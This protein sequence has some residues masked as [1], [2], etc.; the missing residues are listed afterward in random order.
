[1]A[2]KE[3]S[4]DNK[5]SPA[6]PGKVINPAQEQSSDDLP[7]ANLDDNVTDQAVKDIAT[8]ESDQVLAVEDAA[9]QPPP[10]S[11]G[12][13]KTK[14]KRILKDK[15]TWIG[16]AVVLVLL[17][18]VPVTRYKVL[19]LVLK[20]PVTVTVVDSQSGHPVSAAQVEFGGAT[21][22]TDG[23]GQVRLR[24]KVGPQTIVA[25]KQYYKQT[26]SKYFVGLKSAK[27]KTVKLTATGRLVPVTVINKITGQ[28]LKGA[29][30]KVLN[31]SAKTDNKGRAV[32]ALPAKHDTEKVKLS[33]SGYNSVE[34]D[35]QVTDQAVKANNFRLV[36]A[37]HIYFLSNLSG[38]IDVVR[39]NLDGSARKTVFKGTGK[40]DARSTSLL[41][42][43]DWRYAVLKSNREG[44]QASLFV[45]DGNNDKVTQFDSSIGNFDLI[46]WY[47]HAFIYDLSRDSV[48][49]WQSG[50][51][52][53]KSYD[54]DHSQ[55]NQLDQTEGEGS[56][57]SYAYQGFFNFYIVNGA[58][59]YNTQWYTFNS[60]GA[61]YDAG[62]KNDTIRAAQP[63]GHGKKD[64]Q[65]WPANTNGAVTATLYEPDA[66][67]Y[68]VSDNS[69]KTNYY[70]YEH[71]AVAAASIDAGAF[72][73]DY[74]TY[75]LSPSGNRTFWS[76]LRDGRNT[77]FV[78][79]A[80]AKSKQQANTNGD[81]APYGWFS[82]DYLLVSKAS[83][84]LYI[85]PSKSQ[86][87][88][89][90]PFK[91]SNYYKPPQTYRGYGYGYGG[92]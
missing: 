70:V 1:M 72:N 21:G 37:G 3:E 41:A 55:L 81:Y 85:M 29:E 90:Q 6:E 59:V 66:I 69:G 8:A 7:Q 28:P 25:Q 88:K 54:A 65:N 53:L 20:K 9:A 79:N 23:S 32:I 45:I 49:S 27:S 48:S 75:L 44:S 36:P 43:R 38:T 73:S 87:S 77:L 39:T 35:I 24:S 61:A 68:A 33:F 17:L 84:E 19:G 71:Q 89:Q 67:Y 5:V 86:D 80:E 18:A 76:E 15:R 60:S 13:W 42:S 40:E 47:G 82:D 14:F 92:L 57:G 51:Q 83:S 4:D 11:E 31:T 10:I 74:P 50:R 34:T 52:M 62:N 56:S 12:G 2:D 64:Y 91:I 26:D 46:G 78:G 22:K 58:V 30:I 16:V 63:D